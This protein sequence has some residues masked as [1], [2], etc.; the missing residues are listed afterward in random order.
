[1]VNCRICFRYGRNLEKLKTLNMVLETA[2][3][4][5]ILASEGVQMKR[6]KTLTAEILREAQ[7]EHER[8]RGGQRKRE[9]SIPTRYETCMIGMREEFDF[10]RSFFPNMLGEITRHG[11]AR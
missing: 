2:K 1:M 11:L 3:E 5:E 8:L 6:I 4:A 10:G 9:S 7:K